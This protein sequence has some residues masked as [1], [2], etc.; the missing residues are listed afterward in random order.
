MGIRKKYIGILA[1][2]YM[3]CCVV[4]YYCIPIYIEQKKETNRSD[5]YYNLY[6][7]SKYNDKYLDIEFYNSTNL[8]EQIPIPGVEEPTSDDISDRIGLLEYIKTGGEDVAIQIRKER[9]KAWLRKYEN[10]VELYNISV[11]PE[12]PDFLQQ[13]GWALKIIEYMKDINNEVDGYMEYYIFPAQVILKEGYIWNGLNV[14][15]VIEDA[16]NYITTQDRNLKDYYKKGAI[17]DFKDEI[18]FRVNNEFYKLIQDIPAQIKFHKEGDRYGFK[19][20]ENDVA[21]YGSIGN[22]YYKVFLSCTQPKT[23]SLKLID[24][25]EIDNKVRDLRLRVMVYASIIL[26][27]LVGLI[28]I[29]YKK[30]KYEK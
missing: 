23:Y 1:I 7:M 8:Y 27:I 19:T 3:V 10:A 18:R 15:K 25:E 9:E 11:Y 30:A 26:I 21:P 4:I 13:Y 6:E 5:A 24:N 22:S 20:R 16:F 12:G 2:V 14:N 17:I 28:L 29:K